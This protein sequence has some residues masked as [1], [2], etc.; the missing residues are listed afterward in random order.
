MFQILS[1]MKH[2]IRQMF[3]LPMPPFHRHLSGLYILKIN[4]CSLLGIAEI[5]VIASSLTLH[6]FFILSYFAGRLYANA[7]LN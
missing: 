5:N 3:I 1:K 6:D 4:T 7:L 2:V